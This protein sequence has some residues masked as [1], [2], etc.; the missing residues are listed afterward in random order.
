MSISSSAVLV[1]L[2]VSVWPASTIDKEATN[3]VLDDAMAHQSAGK[4]KKDLFAGTSLRKDIEN[5][6]W[7]TTYRG[8]FL[9]HAG[10]GFDRDSFEYLL[11]ESDLADGMP[12]R[13]LIER[14]ARCVHLEAAAHQLGQ[15]KA[16]RM[17]AGH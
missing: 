6:T 12:H 1:S 17:P 8:D 2:N 15:R 14:T 10:K 7:H 3:K 16:R 5:R 13:H 9:V 11:N 4:F